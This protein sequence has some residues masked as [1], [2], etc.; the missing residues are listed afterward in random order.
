MSAYSARQ[1]LMV[2]GCCH[3]QVSKSLATI[4]ESLSALET[5]EKKRAEV[6][7]ETDTLHQLRLQ[8]AELTEELEVT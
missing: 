4:T 5:V 3:P 1:T 2:T 6:E 8:V 7:R